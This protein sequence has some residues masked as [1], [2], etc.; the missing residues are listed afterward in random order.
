M[1]IDRLKQYINS[2]DFQS[3]IADLYVTNDKKEIEK[4]KERFLNAINETEKLYGDGEYVVF[5][6]PGRVEISG[7]HTDHQ[8]GFVVAAS[9]NLDNVCI[10]KKTDDNIVDFFDKNYKKSSVNLS[11]LKVKDEEK[12]KTAALLRGVAAKFNESGYKYGGFKSYQDANVL[13]GSGLSSSACIEVLLTEIYNKLYNDD[14]IDSEERAIISRWVENNYFGKPCGLMDQMA[15]AVGSFVGIDFYDPSK[16]KIIKHDFSFADHGY[17]LLVVNTKADHADLTDEYAAIPNEMRMIAKYFGEEVLSRVDEKNFYDNIS[18]IRKAVNNDRAIL[19]AHHFF[20][21]NKRAKELNAAMDKND[22]D[23]V[24]SLMN[25]SGN[26]SFMNLQNVYTNKNPQSQSVSLALAISKKI[27]ENNGVC[28]VQGGGFAGT[29]QVVV[30]NEF[31]DNYINKM[32]KVFGEDAVLK[33][34]I[35][36]TGARAVVF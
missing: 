25:D 20:A 32:S 6:S 1:Q 15:I 34:E 24:L 18:D 31:V 16:P 17:K 10:A 12:N 33:A 13:V 5:S 4:Q 2:D 36:K 7:N 22:I 14:K 21:E 19:R 35:R 26:S 27:L 9:I 29:I 3:K 23:L 11:N 8:N 28:R 30:K